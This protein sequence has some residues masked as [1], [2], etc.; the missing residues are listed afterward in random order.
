MLIPAG[1]EAGRMYLA[2]TI[3]ITFF[4]LQIIIMMPISVYRPHRMALSQAR[5]SLMWPRRKAVAAVRMPTAVEAATI[6]TM[7]GRGEPILLQAVMVGVM[8][9]QWAAAYTYKALQEKS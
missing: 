8:P 7:R 2:E 5:G 1:S 3:A 4:P 9:A 6:I